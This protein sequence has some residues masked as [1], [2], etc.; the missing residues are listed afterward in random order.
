MP[1]NIFFSDLIRGGADSFPGFDSPKFSMA[2]TGWGTVA[3]EA[4]YTVSGILE[5]Y[6]AA[7]G[8]GNGNFGRYSNPSID[9]K[10]VLAKQTIDRDARLALLQDATRIAMEDYAFI[11]LHFQVNKWAM[12]AGLE[13]SPRTNERTLA[14]GK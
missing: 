11:P 13:H 6:N 5:T 3:G 8:G 10:S 1:R 9:A 4:T 12:K 7:T 2:M 14:V